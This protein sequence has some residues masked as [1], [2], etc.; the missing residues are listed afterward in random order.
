V[1]HAIK[2]RVRQSAGMIK[3]GK[4]EN[5]NRSRHYFRR[6][7][8]LTLCLEVDQLDHEGPS[9]DARS[10]PLRDMQIAAQGR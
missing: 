3:L 2:K 4:V 9:E 7:H 5:G 6:H 1:D 10:S 8:R